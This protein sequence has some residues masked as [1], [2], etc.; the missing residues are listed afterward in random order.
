[1]P[2]GPSF[3]AAVC[4]AARARS[5]T[6]SRALTEAQSAPGERVTTQVIMTAHDN[7]G[8]LTVAL[9]DGWRMYTHYI[10]HG[11]RAIGVVSRDGTHADTGALIVTAAGVY[12]QLNAGA[13]RSL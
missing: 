13:L 7:R 2:S 4:A 11:C 12:A 3:S 10:P 8:H 1:M 6:G 5:R 9:G